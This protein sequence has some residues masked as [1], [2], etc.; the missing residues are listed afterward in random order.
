[1][2]RRDLLDG[3]VYLL[4]IAIVVLT[5]SL[6]ATRPARAAD[7]ISIGSGF[8]STCAGAHSKPNPH[9]HH[10]KPLRCR[11]SSGVTVTVR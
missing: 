8:V 11:S 1:M 10:A 3:F 7:G 2:T 9:R 6:L 4:A 5:L